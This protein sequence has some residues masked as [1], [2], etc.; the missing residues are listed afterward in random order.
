VAS[1][2]GLVWVMSVKL[3]LIRAVWKAKN[4]VSKEEE[5]GNIYIYIKE[6]VF[7][8]RAL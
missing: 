7:Q 6:R 5:K 1:S 2:T 8:A 4:K 3:N